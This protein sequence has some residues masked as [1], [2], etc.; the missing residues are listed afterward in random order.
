VTLWPLRFTQRTYLKGA[1]R[2]FY[3][4]HTRSLKVTLWFLSLHT[5]NI[6]KKWQTIWLLAKHKKPEGDPL[7]SSL[8]PANK[9]YWCQT[10]KLSGHTRSVKVTL[11]SLRFTQRTYLKGAGR[12]GYL[13]HTRSLKVTLWSLRFTRRTN[14]KGARR[15]SYLNTQEAYK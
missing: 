12:L 5:M 14:Y 1:R 8:H 10:I 4:Q 7:V 11:W 13:E 9:L 6:F 2:L 3:F 15:L